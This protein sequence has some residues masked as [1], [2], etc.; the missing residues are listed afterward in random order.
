[1]IKPH[2]ICPAAYRGS[3]FRPQ[4]FMKCNLRSGNFSK[5]LHHSCG[6]FSIVGGIRIK[7]TLTIDG[8]ELCHHIR[9][10][11]HI[12]SKIAHHGNL[13]SRCFI[14][15]LISY[16][17]PKR[18][19]ILCKFSLMVK[20]P[21]YFALFPHQKSTPPGASFVP[22]ICLYPIVDHPP[23]FPLSPPQQGRQLRHAALLGHRF[24]QPRQRLRRY[25]CDTGIA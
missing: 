6:N 24:P 16:P 14:L 2:P 19:L 18:K 21:L 7:Q 8:I 17:K 11:T 23:V 15:L 9:V 1:M 3:S 10:F 22:L 13:I 5:L 25:Q 12:V 20:S 4:L